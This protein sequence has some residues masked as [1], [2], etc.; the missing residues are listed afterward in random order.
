MRLLLRPYLSLL[1]LVPKSNAMEQSEMDVM[2]AEINAAQVAE[3]EVL[4]NHAYYYEIKT[5]RLILQQYE[6]C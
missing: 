2:V 5:N 4:S 6:K 3:E 1:L